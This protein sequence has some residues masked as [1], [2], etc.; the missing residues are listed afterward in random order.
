MP[1][2]YDNYRTIGQQ[3]FQNQGK[4][5]ISS[6]VGG[7]KSAI[8]KHFRRLGYE[9]AWQSRFHDYIIRNDIAYNRIVEYIQKNPQNWNRDKFYDK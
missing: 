1:C 6:I 7:Y 3:R 4:N 9:F 2:L 8:T 5:T